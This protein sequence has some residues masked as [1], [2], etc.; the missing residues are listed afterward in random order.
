MV[1]HT[2]VVA[3]TGATT[4]NRITANH[5]DAATGN[6]RAVME[7]ATTASHPVAVVTVSRQEAAVGANH[8]DVVA[9]TANRP[10]VMAASRPD[11]SLNNRGVATVVVTANHPTTVSS[12]ATIRPACG[13]ARRTTIADAAT[14]TI[15]A[16]AAAARDEA[17]AAVRVASVSTTVAGMKA[18]VRAK[19][20]AGGIV[21]QTQ[22]LRGS[23]MKKRNAVVAWTNNA[24]IADVDQRIID[25]LTSASR[26]TS[27][28][29]CLTITQSTRQKSR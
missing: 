9:A 5:Q 10:V 4:A 13:P 22:S 16:A 12:E 6:H 17:G 24:S 11:A 23:A 3:A 1:S 25:V 21:R 19:N 8:Q 26:K 27:T 29:D 20:V 14:I 15:A 7:E 18:A 28:I 2:I